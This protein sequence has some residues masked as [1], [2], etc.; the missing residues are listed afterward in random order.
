MRIKEIRIRK[1]GKISDRTLTFSDGINVLYGENESGKTTVHTF[2]KSMFYGI[3]RQRGRGA[4]NDVYATYEPWENPADY[5]G[6]MWFESG[7]K[8]FR[9]TRNFYKNNVKNELFSETDGRVLDMEAG[10]LDAVLGNVSEAVYDNTVS[11][12]QL[13]SVTGQEL[14]RELQNYMASYQGTGDNSLDLSRAEQ[15]LK[16]SRKGYQV[17]VSRKAQEMEKTKEKISVNMEYLRRELDELRGRKSRQEEQVQSLRI[18]SSREEGEALL[19]ER[20]ARIQNKRK[21]VLTMGVLLLLLLAAGEAA[22]LLFTDYLVPACVLPVL[23]AAVSAWMYAGNRK[24]GGEIL[25]QEKLKK[26][27]L[28]RQE[29]LEWNKESLN[30]ACAE[31]ET[32]FENLAAEYNEVE[33]AMEA[34]A[35]EETEI[36][37]LNLALETI[38]KLSG[39]MSRHLG[40]SLRK[41]TSEILGEITGGKYREVLLDEEFHISVNTQER[42]VPLERLSRGTLEQI[43]FSLRMAAG[44]L[45]CEEEKFPVIL[46]DVFGMYDEERLTAVLAWLHKEGR[47]IVIST[48]HKREMELLEREGIPY[49]RLEL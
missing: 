14:V 8:E 26:R 16:M 33:A 4:K 31:K 5:G 13:K 45:F 30:A 7:G 9:L 19:E 37:A 40:G 46:D 18:G 24:L 27:W 12:A 42:V 47:Q 20:I 29:K 39:N 2:I 25:R 15:M 36:E 34:P 32:A 1:F 43:Y 38:G 3:S 10:A 11:V 44:E 17:Q 41:R 35:P 28:A 22:F 6:T 49:Q 48:C 21:S 23:F